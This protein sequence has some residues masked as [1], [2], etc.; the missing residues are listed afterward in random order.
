MLSIR[1]TSEERRLIEEAARQKGWTVANFLRVSSLERAAHVLNLSRPTS[2]DFSGAAKRLAQVLL[3]PRDAEL[4]THEGMHGLTRCG[5]GGTFGQFD[6]AFEPGDFSVDSLGL[7]DF[8]PAPLTREQVEQLNQ[9][10]KLGGAEFATELI[11]ECRRLAGGTNDP[12]LPPPI[13]P[14]WINNQEKE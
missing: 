13:D 14:S 1:L 10:I 8:R 4:I 3:E 12:N 11:V 7:R 5:E 6:S 2:F 9:A